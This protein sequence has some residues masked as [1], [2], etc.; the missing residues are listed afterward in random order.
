MG[1][2][3]SP[4]KKPRVTFHPNVKIDRYE[5]ETI[6]Y[7]HIMKLN[8]HLDHNDMDQKD[9]LASLIIAYLQR[10]HFDTNM[11]AEVTHYNRVK[12][13]CI[14]GLEAFHGTITERQVRALSLCLLEYVIVS[15]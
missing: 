12:S 7:E 3:Q 14:V 8:K 4:T 2:T 11:T 6:R 5:E 9:Q 1:N 15:I 10:C 13:V